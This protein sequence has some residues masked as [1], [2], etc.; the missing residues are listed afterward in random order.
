GYLSTFTVSDAP[1]VNPEQSGRL[2]LAQWLT[3]PKNPLAAR[4]A[5]NRV[6]H[7]LFGRGLV[8]TVDNFGVNGDKPSHPELVDH[9]AGAFIHQGW[10]VKKLV[11]TLVLTR[12]YQLG[13]EATEKHLTRDPANVLVWRHAPRR[14]TAEEVRDTILAS[15]GTLQRTPPA[16]SPTSKLK[17]IEIRDNGPEAKGIHEAADRALYRSVYLPLLRGLTPKTLAAFDPVEQN[18]VTGQRDETTVPTQAL[19]LL[20]SSFV[21][22]HSLALALRVLYDDAKTDRDRV[23]KSFL[24]TL[25]R[26]PAAAETE[27]AL[28]FLDDYRETYRQARGGD[29]WTSLTATQAPQAAAA[30]AAPEDPDNIDRTDVVVRDEIIPVQTPEA[31]AWTAFAQ[32][33]YG[34]AEFRYLR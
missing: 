10:S 21:R 18:L 19:F 2:Q 7:H 25:G 15:S 33:L 22:N 24:L 1:P 23:R 34:S 13:S 32:S 27:A 17:M 16:G 14:L 26:E 11:R 5:V 31:A 9:L 4:V 6:W 3:S 20:N 12:A 29:L 8:S 30:A 28:S